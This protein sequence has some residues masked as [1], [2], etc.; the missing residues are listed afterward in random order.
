LQG[1]ITS[2]MKLYANDIIFKKK[3]KS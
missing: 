3:W 2:E 1:V